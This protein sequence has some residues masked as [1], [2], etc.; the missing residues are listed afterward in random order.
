MGKKAKN[1]A[2]AAWMRMWQSTG[3][4][5]DQSVSCSATVWMRINVDRPQLMLEVVVSMDSK[6]RKGATAIWQLK[7]RN[8]GE[9]M[10]L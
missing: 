10:R 9:E 8:N 4:I 2:K 3:S 6:E 5:I 1:D 7:L